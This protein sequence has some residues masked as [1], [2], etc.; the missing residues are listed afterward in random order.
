MDSIF[1]FLDD[2]EDLL[3]TSKAVPFTNKISISKEDVFDIISDI[4]LN[5]PG[6]IKQA[7]RIADNCDKIINDANNKA[8]SIIREAEEKADR[9]TMDHEIT[10][11]AKEQAENIV[12]EAKIWAKEVRMG[13]LEYA[14][15]KLDNA[16]RAIRETLD[17]FTKRASEV[18]DYLA[19]ESNI[20]YT[21]K[22]DLLVDNN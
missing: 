20:L 15:E 4:R 9:M 7:Q 2:L 21:S 13:A 22:Q 14:G 3:D 5:L 10:K 11:M 17:I 8:A 19:E 1:K 12:D 6:E 18:E 16:E